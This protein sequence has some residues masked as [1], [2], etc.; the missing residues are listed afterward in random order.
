MKGSVS[1]DSER[2][3]RGDDNGLGSPIH[4]IQSAEWPSTS[5]R[6]FAISEDAK[7]EK[8]KGKMNER[9]PA[10]QLN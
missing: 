5:F 3:P 8:G 6:F 9:I 1:G 7:K 4:Q 10:E 2:G